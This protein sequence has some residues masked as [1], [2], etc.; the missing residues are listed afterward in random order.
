MQREIRELYGQVEQR[1]DQRW[2]KPL[3]TL[4]HFVVAL[5]LKSQRDRLP[6]RSA[7]LTYWTSVAVVPMLLLAF[8]LTGAAGLAAAPVRDLLYETLLA[9]SIEEV[10]AVLD[11]LLNSTSLSALGGVGVI[12]IIFIGAQLFF[13]AERTYNDI[14]YNAAAAGSIINRFF[15][16][17]AALTLGPLLI[18]AGFVLTGQLSAQVHLEQLSLLTRTVSYL[19]PSLVTGVVFVAALRFLPSSTLSWRAVIWGGLSSALMFEAAKRGFSI[20]I[21]LF[22]TKDSMTLIYGTLGLL[23]VFL[24]WINLLWTIV[25]LGVEIAYIRENWAQLVEQQE[26]WVLDPHVETRQPD[27]FFMLSVLSVVGRRYLDASGATSTDVVCQTVGASG[28]H[29]RW[30]LDSL[31]QAGL[32]VKTTDGRYLPAVPLQTTPTRGAIDA[33]RAVTAPKTHPDHPGTPIQQ[34]WLA[35]L[36]DQLDRPLAETLLDD[37]LPDPRAAR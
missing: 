4:V 7:M 8:A 10:S 36:G 37:A 28:Q 2:L 1:L 31:L 30:T 22:G 15:T 17:Y 19:L 20:Y 18:A 9:G 16:F 32:V 33:W 35:A 6:M 5:W 26:R 34:R 21:D 24:L 3:L 14:L 23:P 12:S 11:G 29:V 27:L 25:L 13:Q